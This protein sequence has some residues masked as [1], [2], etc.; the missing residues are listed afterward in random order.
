MLQGVIRPT[1][2]NPTPRQ[3][4]APRKS[5][6]RADMRPCAWCGKEHT[7]RRYCSRGC[8]DLARTQRRKERE[9]G[10]APSVVSTISSC[11]DAA[12]LK[13]L[14][15]IEAAAKNLLVVKGRHHT[16]QAYKQLEGA[17]TCST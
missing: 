5:R 7:G 10:V 1:P 6:A 3:K 8:R 13:R 16:E 14:R 9:S 11:E 2:D 4:P 15:K 12:E 17:V